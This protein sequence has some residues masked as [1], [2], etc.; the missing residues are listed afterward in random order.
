[1]KP[2][3]SSGSQMH[4][5]DRELIELLPSSMKVMAGA[6]AGYDWVD[7]GALAERGELQEWFAPFSPLISLLLFLLLCPNKHKH[8]AKNKRLQETDIEVPVMCI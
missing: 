4:P 8:H 1:M 7:D 6:G 2:F 5:W 3:W